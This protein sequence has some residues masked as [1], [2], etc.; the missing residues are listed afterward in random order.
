MA[1]ADGAV[2]GVSINDGKVSLKTIGNSKPR[3]ICGS[4]IIDAIAELYREHL[5]DWRG[6]F[7]E[8]KQFELADSVYLT[9]KDIQE[10]MLAKVAIG[11]GIAVLLESG[12][13]SPR[14]VDQVIIA[15]AFGAHIDVGQAVSIGLF[16]PIPLDRYIHA[17]NAAGS[18]AV[19]ALLSEEELE[20]ATS[21]QEEIDYLELAVEEGFSEAY[22]KASFFPR[23]ATSRRSE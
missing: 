16:P 15:G 1:A 5:I 11:A 21:L 6:R 20:R 23:Q 12:K 22:T 13:L 2:E 8:G 18:G 7:S 9:Q 10:F 4:G 17:G 3:G 19:R 14:E